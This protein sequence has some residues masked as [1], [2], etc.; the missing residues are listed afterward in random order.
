MPSLC[1]IKARVNNKTY[2]NPAGMIILPVYS[3]SHFTNKRV[4]TIQECL[5]Y[6]DF[7]ET[8]ASGT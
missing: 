2:D 7:K 8:L 1:N 5:K 4:H 6:R 3:M